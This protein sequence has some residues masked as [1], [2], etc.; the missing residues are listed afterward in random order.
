MR[1]LGRARSS[2]DLSLRR[3]IRVRRR[4]STDAWR[5]VAT[6]RRRCATEPARG[7]AAYRTRPAVVL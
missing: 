3:L 5:I 4:R 7:T 6:G 1:G 2:E